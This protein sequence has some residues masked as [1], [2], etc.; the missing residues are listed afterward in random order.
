MSINNINNAAIIAEAV[1]AAIE[2]MKTMTNAEVHVLA[3][4]WAQ[5]A[6]QAS[7]NQMSQAMATVYSDE[8]QRRI[9]SQEKINKVLVKKAIKTAYRET[10]HW[11]R[12]QVY[13]MYHAVAD[14]YRT[15]RA[16]GHSDVVVEARIEALKQI[17]ASK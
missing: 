17:L 15:Y 4:Q 16:S 9:A 6:L 14:A 8:N 3:G 7:W 2:E 12:G 1:A 13:E 5:L 11:D 10:A